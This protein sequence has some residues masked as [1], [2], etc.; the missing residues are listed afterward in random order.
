[1]QDKN[2]CS[3]QDQLLKKVLDECMEEQLSFVPPEREIA[4]MHKFSPEFLE[5]MREILQTK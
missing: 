2:Q 4:R 5:R 1:M 3:A